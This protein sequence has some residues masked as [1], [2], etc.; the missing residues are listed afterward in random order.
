MDVQFAKE[1]SF[2]VSELDGD[3]NLQSHKRKRQEGGRFANLMIAA[4]KED[5]V[6]KKVKPKAGEDI[7]NSILFIQNLPLGTKEI[8]IQELFSTF[9][10]FKE[11]RMVPGKSD[12]AF[13]EYDTEIESGLA[14]Q[15]L[16]GYRI[17]PE[18]E[19]KVTFAKK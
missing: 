12:I 4:K 11:I 14:K 5:S 10:G 19:I 18:K 7:P 6:A 9:Q 15:S 16:H 17:S 2:A 3:E 13:V 8:Q 1:P